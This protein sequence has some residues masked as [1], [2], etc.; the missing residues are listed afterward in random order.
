ME[1]WIKRT[2]FWERIDTLN[3]APSMGLAMRVG[4]RLALDRTKTIVAR[5]HQRDATEGVAYAMSLNDD[6]H[7]QVMEER[8]NGRRGASFQRGQMTS[9]FSLTK[10]P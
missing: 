3:I 1:L 6:A 9:P 10:L 7:Y 4:E 8:Q 5:Y 2:V